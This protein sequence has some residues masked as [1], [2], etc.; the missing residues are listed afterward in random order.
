MQQNPTNN[1]QALQTIYQAGGHFVLCLENKRPVWRSWQKIRPGLDVVLAHDGP[2]G[3]KPWSISTSALDVDSGDPAELVRAWPPMAVLNSRRDAGKHLYYSDT[4]GRGNGHFE[5]Y[6]CAGEIRS[7]RGFLILWHDGAGRLAD[8]LHDPIARSRTWPRDLFELAGLPAVT[9]PAAVKTPTY[10]YQPSDHS[11]RTWAA[12]AAALE[13]ETINRGMRNVKLFDAVR[14]WAYSIPRGDDLD[15]WTRRVRVH[16]LE[17]NRRFPD[18][19]DQAEVKATAYSIS[20]WCW[21]GGGAKWHFD[22]S[23]AAQRR[24]ALKLGRMRRAKNADRDAAIVAAVRAGQSMRAVAGEWGLT[25]EGVRYLVRRVSSEPNQ[26]PLGVRGEFT[27]QQGL[28]DTGR[29]SRNP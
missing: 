24:R 27:K 15:A 2:L 23:S 19:L 28:F 8:A 25:A 16:A 13:L 22:H 4:E 5:V 21:S 3:L 10:T 17:Q 26:F 9:L 12:A 7:A 29:R 11:R 1:P 14:F 6:G 18:P 20:T